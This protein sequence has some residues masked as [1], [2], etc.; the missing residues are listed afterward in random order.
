M[1]SVITVVL[2]DAAGLSKTI[3]SYKEII[4]NDDQF[5][6]IIIDGGS[7]DSTMEVI[8]QNLDAI[9]FYL[10]ERDC[11]IYDAMNKGIKFANGN[12]LWFVNASDEILSKPKLFDESLYTNRF[13]IHC[14]PV[15]LESTNCAYIGKKTWPHQGIIYSRKVFELAGLYE[16]Y[17]LISDRVFYDK[18][19][20]LGVKK[21]LYQNIV[22]AF[23]CGGASSRPN[24]TIVNLK[25]FFQNFIRN[26]DGKSL[27]RLLSAIFEIIV[28]SYL[29]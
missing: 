10:S 9:T 8:E 1:I 28:P 21:H 13:E 24:A 11:G 18:I 14:F 7:S 26:V 25:E 19:I 3:K 22:C 2:N 4:K 23:D 27:R 17:S 20:K 12:Y 5:E 6:L 16:N 29:K 15:L